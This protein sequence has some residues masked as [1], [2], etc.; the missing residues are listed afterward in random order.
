MWHFLQLYFFLGFYSEKVYIYCMKI[1]T[2]TG[3]K[4]ET[5]LFNGE[6]LSKASLRVD[7][8]GTVD[9]LNSLLAV[10][11]AFDP[12]EILNKDLKKIMNLL[13]NLGSDLATPLDSKSKFKPLRITA[14]NIDWLEKKIDEYTEQ[15]PQLKTFI[16]PMGCKSAVFLNQART[17]CRRAERLA[18]NLAEN[19][20]IGTNPLVFLNR[21][22][23]YLFTASRLANILSSYEEVEWD[24]GK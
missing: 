6:R 16:L 7:T 1:Y 12:P 4:G 9:E 18:V 2:K 19:E 22:S 13:F 17:I 15:L 10:V 24:K 11:L 20:D 5:S 23:D 3:D 21:L 8:Y 14:G